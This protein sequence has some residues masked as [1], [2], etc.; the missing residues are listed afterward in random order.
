MYFK[1]LCEHT[2]AQQI[3]S[4]SFVPLMPRQV[5]LLGRTRTPWFSLQVKQRFSPTEPSFFP[6]ALRSSSPSQ[7]PGAKSV[8][9]MYLMVPISLELVRRTWEPSCSFTGPS[10]GA[11]V[12]LLQ[13]RRSTELLDLGRIEKEPRKSFFVIKHPG[14]ICDSRKCMGEKAHPQIPSQKNWFRSHVTNKP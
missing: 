5:T 13:L 6:L 7:I 9:P 3:S 1:I 8:G 11:A 4:T 14:Q 10:E 2:V 12:L